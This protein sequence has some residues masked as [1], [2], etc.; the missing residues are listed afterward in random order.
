[1]EI[2]STTK[3]YI[4]YHNLLEDKN[5]KQFVLMLTD[6]SSSMKKSDFNEIKNV[7]TLIF[8]LKKEKLFF[9]YKM[10]LLM[11]IKFE[12]CERINEI[13]END[14]QIYNLEFV[15]EKIQE[16]KRSEVYIE[17][18]KV[19]PLYVKPLNEINIRIDKN[20]DDSGAFV[21]PASDDDNLNNNNKKNYNPC[22]VWYEETRI[23][24]INRFHLLR[25]YFGIDRLKKYKIKSITY[26]EIY[27]MQYKKLAKYHNKIITK[28]KREIKKCVQMLNAYLEVE[29]HYVTSM[30]TSSSD[31]ELDSFSLIIEDQDDQ[32]D[33][34]GDENKDIYGVYDDSF[35][36]D[37]ID[38]IDDNDNYD[39]EKLDEEL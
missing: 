39:N 10:S 11:Y 22:S 29:K 4:I 32:D 15:V 14:C 38:D 7:K 35:E 19:L 23:E 16:L 17:S 5:E 27:G 18:F 21:T 1:M 2:T 25:N 6:L 9:S 33:Q 28:I 34:D 26:E 13:F 37:E 30:L 3:F 12:L 31:L 20:E 36:I 8:N 24:I